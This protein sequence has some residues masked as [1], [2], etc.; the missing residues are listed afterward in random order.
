[1]FPGIRDR[2]CCGVMLLCVIL[3]AGCGPP[4]PE[5]AAGE[6]NAAG[7]LASHA[8][9]ADTPAPLP[10]VE[11]HLDTLEGGPPP[12]VDH[13]RNPFWLGPARPTAT[14]EETVLPEGDPT[15]APGAADAPPA[16][17]ERVASI[18]FLGVVETPES[19]GQMAVLS[20]SGVVHYGRLND[21]V[22]GRYR[23]VALDRTAIV[24]ERVRDG[25]RQTLRPSGSGVVMA[26]TA[27]GGA[28]AAGAD[29]LEFAIGQGRVTLIAAGVPLRDVLAAWTRA[30]DTR[31]VGAEALGA[32][33]VSLHLAGVAEAEAL[34]LL[35]QPAAGYLAARRAPSLPGASVYDR[36]RIHAER[37]APRPAP[38]R[39]AAPE[40]SGGETAASPTT[41]SESDQRERLQRLMPPA[42]ASGEAATGPAREAPP[43]GDGLV[44]PPG[45]TPRPGMIVE[46]PP[47]E[48]E[49]R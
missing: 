34:R 12:G 47:P 26:A 7:T 24:I 14:P 8:R 43:P 36:V 29:E 5:A 33:P 9:P 2:R 35:L 46:L 49:S 44:L 45:A 21:V 23:I 6:A 22:G 40:P 11:V 10:F 18:R 38:A 27:A 1:M 42:V 13:A 25:E 28:R 4:S 17:V 48:P 37:R 41:L 30:G 31:F 3:P 20:D 39:P 15:D 16:A 32:A 19:V